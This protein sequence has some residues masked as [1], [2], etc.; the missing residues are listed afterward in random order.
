MKTQPIRMP[1]L[2]LI[3]APAALGTT[4]VLSPVGTAGFGRV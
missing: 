4:L 2:T 3:L 1:T